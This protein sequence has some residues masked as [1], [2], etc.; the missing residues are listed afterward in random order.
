LNDFCPLEEGEQDHRAEL[1]KGQSLCDGVQQI[2]ELSDT[3]AKQMQSQTVDMGKESK[4]G[5][6]KTGSRIRRSSDNFLSC[7]KDWI[8]L[9]HHSPRETVQ[10]LNSL[11]FPQRESLAPFITNPH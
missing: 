9:E 2:H 5:R 6:K 10:L 3:T 1:Q 7:W 8:T 4:A 11:P